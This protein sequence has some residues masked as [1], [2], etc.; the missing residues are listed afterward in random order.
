[1]GNLIPAPLS[2]Y[3]DATSCDA[4]RSTDNVPEYSYRPT[5]DA[6]GL[7][8][9]NQVAWTAAGTTLPSVFAEQNNRGNRG[10]PESVEMAVA[11]KFLA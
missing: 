10:Q 4:S 8:G 7:R 6:E 11:C 3:Y 2:N 5:F 9:T 1:M